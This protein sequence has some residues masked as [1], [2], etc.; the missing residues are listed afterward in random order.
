MA[1]RLAMVTAAAFTGAAIYVGA[2]EQPARLHLND[3]ALLTHWQASYVRG[4]ALQAS[5]AFASALFGLFAFWRNGDWHWLVGAG[6]IFANWPYTLLMILPINKRLQAT[7]PNAANQETRE[8]IKTWG[9]LH[10]ARALFGLAATAA[11]LWS[12]S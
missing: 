11:Y 12:L 5:L 1:E 7:E 10:T 8:L 2:A 4:F 3:T 9:E 6:L